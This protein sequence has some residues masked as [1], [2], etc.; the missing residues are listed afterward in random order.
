[1]SNLSQAFDN[2]C[3]NEPCSGVKLIITPKQKDLGGF[4]V[5]RALPVVEQRRVGPWIFF[6]HAGP[7]VFPPG[8][9][10]DVRPHP[11]INLA[12]V[13]Y[14]FDGAIMHRDSLG[15]ELAIVPGDINLMVAG[16]G[17][18]HSERT[19]ED[20][21]AAGHT[22]HLLQL[23]LALPEEDEETDPAFFHYDASELPTT[24][25][26]SITIRVMMG[27]AYGLK[28]PVKTFAQTLYFEADIAAGKSL[29]IPAEE[30]RAIYVAGGNVEINGKEVDEFS[31]AI[32]EPDC[33]I[34][35]KASRDSRI[36]VIGGEALSDRHLFWNF[37]SSR[38]ERLEQAKD[39]WKNG[40][41]PKVPGDE[42]EFIPLPE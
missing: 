9:G 19:P 2:T 1:M 17:I 34:T 4:S 8:E 13:S 28:S 30:E 15:N 25:L 16:K 41:F 40:R 29:E 12:T 33:A 37:V 26:D 14:L 20:V 27:Q 10:I 36:A 31:M 5:R 24:E 38:K 35:V 6:D 39:D 22:L 18:V 3:A 21:R 32:L 42:E 7:A 23:W 11:H